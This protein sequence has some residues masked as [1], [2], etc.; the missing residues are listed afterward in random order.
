MAVMLGIVL[1]LGLCGCQH[2]QPA[3]RPLVAASPRTLANGAYAV[4]RE[5]ATPQEARGDAGVVIAYDRRTYSGAPADEPLVYVAVD[6]ADYIP[7]VIEGTPVM[8]S[9]GRG[10][11]VLT[12][13]LSRKYV[14][15]AEDFTRAHLGRGRIAI[16]VDGQIVT[17]HKVRSV[18][19]DGRLQ[20]TRCTDKACAVIRAK[21]VE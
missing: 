13:S 21:L 11:D 12:V 10:K 2:S 17:L 16:V 8:T 7:L 18:I 5:G 15:R 9:D 3:T 19:T 20:I 1:A 4:L 14:R 6:P